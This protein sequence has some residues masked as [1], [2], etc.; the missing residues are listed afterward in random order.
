M[1]RTLFS[2]LLKD[3]E[4]LGWEAFCVHF[5][6]TGRKLADETGNR[7]LATAGMGRTTF[8]R[9]SSG[10]WYGRPRGEAAQILERMFERTI[11]ELFS[12]APNENESTMVLHSAAARIGSRWP[13][14]NVL[15]P[16]GGPVGTW[17]IAGRQRLDGTSAAVHLLPVVRHGD[18][19]VRGLSRDGPRDLE[20]FLRPARRGFLLCVE[21]LQDE[22]FD[23]YVRDAATT[24]RPAL[25]G[26]P[27]PGALPIPSAYL[28]D[29]LTYGILWAVTQLDDSLLADDQALDAEQ[30]LLETYLSLPRSAPS[31]L[32]VDLTSVGSSWMGSAF[33][34]R[35]IQQEL[36]DATEV[37]IFWTREQSGEEAA[38][39]L[40]FKHKLDYLRAF[41]RFHGTTAQTVR[42]FCLPEAEVARSEKY[43]RVLLLLAVAL[44]ER[45][46]IRV[47]VVPSPEYTEVDGVALVP[48]HRA[49]VANW[50]RVPAGA[51]WAADSTSGRGDLRTYATVFADAQDLDVLVGEDPASRLRSLAD[52]LGLDWGWLTA[53]CHALG[54]SGVA[55]LVRPRSRLLTVDALD[56]SLLFLGKMA[57]S[58]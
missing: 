19:D 14:S 43:E 23:L 8:D 22:D 26:P 20:R 18:A 52:Y 35:H 10:T 42:V 47:R 15:L 55:G 33:C 39:W 6:A 49:V 2:L 27:V 9:W 34:A 32:L 24:R 48:G 21:K 37:P 40:V 41:D 56:E 57:S 54:E 11:E 7:R 16:A 17:E 53:R 29:D 44:M 12:P 30:H 51:L 36:S 45:F 5:T 25:P 38:C 3:R 31:Q 50:V 4:L 58:R 28:L 13:T 1:R 46:R